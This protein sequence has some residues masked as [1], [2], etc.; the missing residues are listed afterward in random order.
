MSSVVFYPQMGNDIISPILCSKDVNKIYAFGPL[1]KG[2]S[3][4]ETIR[5][6]T[7]IAEMGHTGVF[8]NEEEEIEDLF[9]FPLWC[10]KSVHFKT[11]NLYY[12]QFKYGFE[13]ESRRTITLYYYYNASLHDKKW[14]IPE[15]EKVDYIVYKDYDLEDKTL[16]ERKGILKPTT[17]IFSTEFKLLKEWNA[18]EEDI[19]NQEFVD[20]FDVTKQ[21]LLKMYVLNMYKNKEEEAKD[22]IKGDTDVGEEKIEGKMEEIS[23]NGPKPFCKKKKKKDKKKDKKK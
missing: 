14:P 9:D 15:N 6:I 3:L 1:P 8:E 22:A 19:A 5:M 21:R 13:D 20:V 23:A 12:L 2:Q 4:T 7:K 18:T 17:K 11:K 16:F 10:A